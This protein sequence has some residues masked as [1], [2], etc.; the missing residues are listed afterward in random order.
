M[1]VLKRAMM[2]TA[3]IAVSILVALASHGR[4]G[5]APHAPE[6]DHLLS[7]QDFDNVDSIDNISM[8]GDPLY[9]DDEKNMSLDTDGDGQ[10]DINFAISSSKR[11]GI[12]LKGSVKQ[13]D[14]SWKSMNFWSSDLYRLYR[15]YLKEKI[16]NRT[17]RA[18]DFITLN[19]SGL[20]SLLQ[21]GK[22]AVK[23][24]GV[25]EEEYVRISVIDVDQD[26]S[27]EVLASV[28]NQQDECITAVYELSR[29]DAAPFTYFGYFTSY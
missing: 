13:K 25:T 22:S 1:A 21:E 12:D 10:S 15:D 20:F 27:I 26:G 3:V 24:G 19:V 6:A 17:F 2:I 23:G 4:E 7:A 18:K 9:W 29:T 14:G 16:Q 11:E 5:V 8:Y 28:G